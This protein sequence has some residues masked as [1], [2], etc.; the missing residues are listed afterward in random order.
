MGNKSSE[1]R[2]HERNDQY[3][4]FDEEFGHLAGDT[5]V[6]AK[7]RS[8]VITLVERLSKVIISLKTAGRQ[9]KDIEHTLNHWFQSFPATPV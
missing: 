3:Q 7:H 5:I 9:T 4:T 8:A 1:G 2:I 6:G